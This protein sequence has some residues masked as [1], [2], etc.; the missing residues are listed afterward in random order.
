MTQKY[1]YLG[2]IVTDILL[3]S[4]QSFYLR[5]VGSYWIYSLMFSTF[6][7]LSILAKVYYL[8]WNE[9]LA[10]TSYPSKT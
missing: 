3:F 6:I 9:I 10:S 4:S 5:K 2:I 8:I 7:L 1:H